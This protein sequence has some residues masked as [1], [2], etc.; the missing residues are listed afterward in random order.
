[1]KKKHED[2]TFEKFRCPITQS[3]TP[4]PVAY[5]KGQ[6]TYYFDR[7]ALSTWL[8]VSDKNPRTN[9]AFDNEFLSAFRTNPEQFICIESQQEIQN[10]IQ[11]INE[12]IS[13]VTPDESNESKNSYSHSM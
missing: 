13:I 2:N 1:M 7:E 4:Y 12:Q 11:A 5:K 3:V 8:R 10:K 6:H 9:Q